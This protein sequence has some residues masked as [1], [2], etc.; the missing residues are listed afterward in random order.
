MIRLA[1]LAVILI[2]G[3]I[4][5]A[6]FSVVKSSGTGGVTNQDTPTAPAQTGQEPDA[7][8]DQDT[9]L[10]F[11]ADTDL[12]TGNIALV[13]YDAG[14]NGTDLVV[15]DA[16]AIRAAQNDAWVNTETTGGEAIGKIV[17]AMMGVPPE[18]RIASLYRDDALVFHVTCGS[19]TCGGFA[20]SENIEYAGLLDAAMPLI[21][22][23]EQ[24][25][26]Y[27]AYLDALA[28]I[29]AEPDFALFGLGPNRDETHPVPQM[30]PRVTVSLPTISQ[31][32]D[33][34]LNPDTHAALLSAIVTDALPA[35][36]ALENVTITPRGNAILVDADNGRAATR[37]GAEIPFPDV[38]FYRVSAT[39]S[40]VDDLTTGTLDTLT[41]TTLQRVDFEDAASAFIAGL[42]LACADCFDVQ[43]KGTAYDRA[44]VTLREPER[45]YLDYY[46]LRDPP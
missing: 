13:L 30:T 9:R 45:Y 23:E 28:F 2:A 35:G 3:A 10:Y 41:E 15:T 36:A 43:I 19:T 44:T 20:S 5:F 33:R 40:G 21:R 29:A 4:A 31:P 32:A 1:S 26:D 37:G 46:D 16:D 18:Q 24:F 7:V 38:L 8:P 14:P 17:L 6:G 22:V 25:D 39:I 11:L 27:T 42:G 12:A 34:P